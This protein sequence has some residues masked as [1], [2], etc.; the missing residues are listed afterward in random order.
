MVQPG[1]PVGPL[2][3]G[4]AGRSHFLT[5]CIS[6]PLPLCTLKV[7]LGDSGSLELAWG[8]STDGQEA[9]SQLR[10]PPR[11]T[12]PRQA[13]SSPRAHSPAHLDPAL[14]AVQTAIERRRHREQVGGCGPRGSGGKA[15]PCLP[16]HGEVSSGPPLHCPGGPGPH[17][18]REGS[19]SR[20]LLG[21]S[22]PGA[23]RLTGCLPGR[24]CVCSYS[25]PGRPR[26][27]SRSSCPR[28][29][30]SFGPR[31]GSCR[32]GLRNTR[33][34]W[35]GWRPRGVRP[36]T[37]RGLQSSWEG[38]RKRPGRGSRAGSENPHCMQEG[39]SPLPCVPVLLYT[40]DPFPSLGLLPVP[41]ALCPQAEPSRHHSP[42][43]AGPARLCLPPACRR[44]PSGRPFPVPPGPQ[45]LGSHPRNP[46]SGLPS[47]T[48]GFH[49]PLPGL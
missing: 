41:T 40:G 39:Q 28:A 7:A 48:P 10:S 12:S 42:S 33:P 25:P 2:L 37:A 17:R 23:S 26:P 18:A 9:R 49:T 21:E 34:S 8:S 3:Q 45:A 1:R 46:S 47:R 38:G 43:P 30:R 13:V 14:R 44:T 4:T 16:Q 24:S 5:A 19:G 35:A 27:D 29:S 31:R 32:A 22:E 36:G 15:A 11:A 6:P 20:F